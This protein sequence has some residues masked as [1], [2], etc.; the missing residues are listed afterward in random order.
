MYINNIV[1]NWHSAAKG[2][3]DRISQVRISDALVMNR[4]QQL[5]LLVSLPVL[6][7]IIALFASLIWRDS[8]VAYSK[9]LVPFGRE[10]VYRPIVGDGINLAPWRHEVAISA[11]LEILNSDSLKIDVIRKIGALRILGI[12]DQP[13]E[14]NAFARFKERI[15]IVLRAIGVIGPKVSLE[16]RSL[17]KYKAGLELNGIKDTN[18]IHLKFAHPDRDTAILVL[19]THL[20]LYFDQRR[21]LYGP[22]D[23]DALEKALVERENEM[24]DTQKALADYKSR[25]NITV[26]DLEFRNAFDQELQIRQQILQASVALTQAEGKMQSNDPL[27]ELASETRAELLA[28]IT[29]QKSVILEL[30]GKLREVEMQIKDLEM[31]KAEIERLDAELQTSRRQLQTMRDKVNEVRLERSLNDARWSNVRVIE[32]PNALEVPT[33]LSPITRILIAGFLGLVLAV[34]ILVGL[35]VLRERQLL[36]TQAPAAD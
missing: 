27:S 17:V 22:P 6:A 34:A 26:I 16:E 21:S 30:Q 12:E 36:G 20:D 14:L 13:E 8:Y 3:V 23:G 5:T 29:G 24:I 32:P 15:K 11:E 1:S 31:H 28:T 19:K 33:G 7:M 18:V 10:Y 35:A 9:L 4:R 25:N 2:E